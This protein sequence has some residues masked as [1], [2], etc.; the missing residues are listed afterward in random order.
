MCT[1]MGVEP[2]G[3]NAVDYP[4]ESWS[5]FGHLISISKKMEGSD[6]WNKLVVGSILGLIGISSLQGSMAETYN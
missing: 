1:G 4:E 6:V 2:V 5:F 3:L